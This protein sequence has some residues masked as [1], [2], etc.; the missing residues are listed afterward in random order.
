MLAAAF[1]LPIVGFPLAALGVPVAPV[2][3]MVVL[4]ICFQKVK[5]KEAL[6]F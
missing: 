5:V 3:A 2:A 1:L 6:L 4:G